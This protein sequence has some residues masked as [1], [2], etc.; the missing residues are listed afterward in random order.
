MTAN[1]ARANAVAALCTAVEPV[2]L[3]RH[4][5]LKILADEQCD[6]LVEIICEY[7]DVSTYADAAQ[8]LKSDPRYQLLCEKCGWTVAMVCPECP[9]CGCYDGQCDG[10]RH[11]EYAEAVEE[12][13]AYEEGCPECGASH[14]YHCECA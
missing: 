6:A 8:I 2:R 14:E 3:K 13:D 12:E 9:G 10:W 1:H 5:A 4:D 11:H 7:A